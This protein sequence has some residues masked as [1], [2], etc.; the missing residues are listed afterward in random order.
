MDT[1][2]LRRLVIRPTTIFPVCSFIEYGHSVKLDAP[3]FRLWPKAEFRL[4]S[5][6]TGRDRMPSLGQVMETFKEV[7]QARRN[8][9]EPS[10]GVIQGED[11]ESFDAIL[12]HL[13][14]FHFGS[15]LI[16]YE[17]LNW[18]LDVTTQ[19]ESLF[20]LLD[21]PEGDE[22]PCLV[23]RLDQSNTLID[24]GIYFGELMDTEWQGHYLKDSD[25]VLSHMPIP[26]FSNALNQ[27]LRTVRCFVL[28]CKVVERHM[29]THKRGDCRKS[30]DKQ[31]QGTR[32]PPAFLYLAVPSLWIMPNPAWFVCALKHNLPPG[33]YPELE[34]A[35]DQHESD[36]RDTQVAFG[37][38]INTGST[39]NFVEWV[40]DLL[41]GPGDEDRGSAG[42]ECWTQW[43]ERFDLHDR[44]DPK[45][46]PIRSC[47]REQ[48][49]ST[50]A[51]RKSNIPLHCPSPSSCHRRPY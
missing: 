8:H 35:A 32:N 26:F 38:G 3:A 5:L 18:I 19:L 14:V 13:E 24:L 6:I 50:R 36:G 25:P 49:V 27:K 33:I 15:A 10:L 45:L 39:D 43:L 41:Y 21:N 42:P 29:A 1:P 7:Q 37:D 16:S 11:E 12:K 9:Q 51:V 28:P 44:H 2:T 31:I 22:Q 34:S 46:C 20:V 4:T 30:R 47:R 17:L 23:A 48:K 40:N